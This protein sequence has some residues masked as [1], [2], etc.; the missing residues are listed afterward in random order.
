MSALFPEAILPAG[1]PQIVMSELSKIARFFGDQPPDANKEEE[2]KVWREKAW[3]RAIRFEMDEF[4]FEHGIAPENHPAQRYLTELARRLPGREDI[5]PHVILAAHWPEANAAAFPDGTIFISPKQLPDAE[6]EEALLG[7]LAHDNV[8]AYRQHGLKTSS[9]IDDLESRETRE[10][11]RGTF[12]ITS[13]ARGQEYEADLRGAIADLEKM[14]VNPLGYKLYLEKAYAKDKK[15]GYMDVAHGPTM[16]RALNVATVFHG[17]DLASLAADFH[18]IPSEVLQALKEPLKAEFRSL[19]FRPADFATLTD[20]RE[21]LRADRREI[22]KTLPADKL[23]LAIHY[24]KAHVGRHFGQNSR[25]PEDEEALAV[26]EKRF[27]NE[28]LPAGVPEAERHTMAILVLEFFA[29]MAQSEAGAPAAKFREHLLGTI[30]PTLTTLEDWDRLRSTLTEHLPEIQAPYATRSITRM[31]DAILLLVEREK[32]FWDERSGM[33]RPAELKKFLDDWSGT[34]ATLNERFGLNSQRPEEIRR[35][36]A[37]EILEKIRN[38]EKV[39]ESLKDILREAPYEEERLEKFYE[40]GSALANLPLLQAENAIRKILPRLKSLAAGSNLREIGMCMDAFY[41]GFISNEFSYQ[42]SGEELFHPEYYSA[43][44]FINLLKGT[45]AF[46]ELPPFEQKLVIFSIASGFG[47]RAA[48]YRLAGEAVAGEGRNITGIGRDL[49]TSH[50]SVLER[51]SK[52]CFRLTDPDPLFE[53]LPEGGTEALQLMYNLLLRPE[54][55]EDYFG[56]RLPRQPGSVRLLVADAANQVFRGKDLPAILAELNLLK[57]KGIP[58]A[59]LLAELPSE[60][61]IIVLAITQAI[62]G[63]AISGVSLKDL[64]TASEWIPDPFLRGAFQRFAKESHWPSLS[65]EEK[66]DLILPIG[67]TKGIRSSYAQ[68]SFLEEDMRTRDQFRDVRSRIESTVNDIVTEGSVSGG[69]MA[70]LSSLDFKFRDVNRFLHGLL[71]SAA[72]DRELKEFLYKNTDLSLSSIEEL[73]SDPNQRTKLQLRLANEALLSLYTLDPMGRQILLRNLL[74]SEH[75]ALP[76]LDKRRAFF[77]ML[78]KDWIV[79]ERGQ[80]RINETLKEIQ[81]V[82]AD[83]PEWELL[84]FAFQSVLADRIAVPPDA[85]HEISWSDIYDVQQ[86]LEDISPK[87]AKEVLG[88]YSWRAIPES[89]EIKPWK[90]VTGYKNFSTERLRTALQKKGSLEVLAE[91]T[92]TPLEFAKETACKIGMLG[93]RFMQL[94]PQF[95][96]MPE[97]QLRELYDVF[98]AVKGQSKV[99]ALFLMEREWPGM[100]E[101]IAEVGDRIGGGSAVT[102][103][104][105]VLRDGTEEVLKV[106]NPNVEYHMRE[107]LRLVRQ[108]LDALAERHGG[109]YIAARGAL[110]DIEEWILRDI[111]FNDFLVKDPLFRAANDGYRPENFSYAIKVPASKG[112]ASKFFSREEKVRGDTLTK[113]E[114]LVADGHNMKEVVSLVIRNYVEQISVGRVHS[115]V[116]IGNFMVTPG[117]DVAI[118]DR[119]FPLELTAAEQDL[120][121]SFLSP[122]SGGDERTAALLDYLAPE[123]NAGLRETARPV[124]EAAVAALGERQWSRAYAAIAEL[125]RAGVKVPLTFTLLLKNF[126]SLELMAHKAGFEGVVEGFAY[127][128]GS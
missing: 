24:L 17:V 63:G 56:I 121:L 42:E 124:V 66:L 62:E 73:D 88:E 6:I 100:W 74:A 40:H 29:G 8:H 51:L 115:D 39:Y 98:D 76:S 116:H 1:I 57:E 86:D 91:K 14:G 85:S 104:D 81:A 4:I 114:K 11:I 105:V 67:E 77:T 79:P 108:A 110:D 78:F 54:A 94:L 97:E 52:N 34:L 64:L 55:S 113:W 90:H 27:E 47:L 127:E 87:K 53:A 23:S 35:S 21:T 28:I 3:E 70:I 10:K 5:E 33:S 65:F 22:V 41:V 58:V 123:A 9:K 68:E 31:A 26:L 13:M 84:Y 99:A 126:K 80:E 49:P 18:S 12:E 112:P 38:N 61:G 20:V 30:A 71:S 37:R 75:G 120:I 15:Y 7:V 107:A 109:G 106:R 103:Y 89:A 16:D 72:G 46:A 48:G 60:N 117:K 36:M 32:I 92:M 93:V 69:I 101:E 44:T 125:K 128:P 50:I 102:V 118:L 83:I 96:D 82:L 45:P 95:V 25:D 2:A 119:N 122:F 59:D 19:V 111:N 43:I